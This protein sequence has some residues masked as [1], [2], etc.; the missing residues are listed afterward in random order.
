MPAA[1][2][3]VKCL[4][5]SNV[6]TFA[7]ESV[8][9]YTSYPTAPHFSPMVDADTCAGWLAA[10]P[11][12]ADLSVYVHVPFCAA[13]C[14][15]CGCHTKVV[16]R[17]EP[18]EAY[19]DRLSDEAALLGRLAGGR[20][21]VRIH[22]GGGTPSMLG[23]ARLVGFVERLGE[24]FDLSNL[25]EHAIELDPRHVTRDLTVALGR[26][27][28]NR[29]S[30]G[31]QDFSPRVQAAIGR[32]QP[33]GVVADSVAMLRAGG[34]ARINLD[35]MY[36]LPDQTEDDVRTS[37]TLAH[38]LA[39]A[40]LALFGYAHVPWFKSHQRLIDAAALPGATQRLEQAQAARQTLLAL[41]YEAVGLDHFAQPHD[42]LAVA[43]R[44][45]G[46]RRNF[47]GYTTD[48][49]DALIGL[50]ASAISRL[51]DGF[52]QNAPDLAGYSRAVAAGR[53]A[54]SRGIALSADDRLRGAII[55]RMMCDF[56]VDLDA[57][58]I[59]KAAGGWDDALAE[60]TPLEAAG[61]VV[62]DGRKIT[63]T[64][65]G[66]PFVRLAAAA[67][68]AYLRRDQARHSAAV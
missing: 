52:A 24:L 17:R 10:L 28:I 22:W 48:Q 13:M 64:E 23:P 50:G 42:D 7:S 59:G 27:G 40:R 16:R 43:A 4:M 68:D 60:M 34:I 18:I 1:T 44:H 37:A 62:V 56:A 35:L 33:F 55:E 19:A 14:R 67:F 21:I 32:V 66:R 5:S 58:E 29:A 49:A 53:P 20:R 47:Q 31:V 12:G 30:L 46:L 63:M 54:T 2:P 15:Y 6:S 51:P 41:G 39:P 61:L 57:I 65:L 11:R 9:R 25:V 45:G 36:G 8:P 3:A 38:A 26:I